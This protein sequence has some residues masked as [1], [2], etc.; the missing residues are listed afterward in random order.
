MENLEIG[1]NTLF[2]VISMIV[3]YIEHGMKQFY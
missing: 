3:R 2:T 1:K